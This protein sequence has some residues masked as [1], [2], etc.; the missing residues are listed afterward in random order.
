M[1]ARTERSPGFGPSLAFPVAQWRRERSGAPVEGGARY[2]GGAAPVLHRLPSVPVRVLQL[3][4]AGQVYRVGDPVRKSGLECRLEA[5][6]LRLVG[7]H[8][9]GRRL[10]LAPEVA[11]VERRDGVEQAVCAIRALAATRV[12]RRSSR[13]P[14]SPSTS[15]DRR[16]QRRRATGPRRSRSRFGYSHGHAPAG[17]DL[18]GPAP[19]APPLDRPGC[20]PARAS[21]RSPARPALRPAD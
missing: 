4:N 18:A 17:R 2:S 10:G 7:R 16:D 1:V 12:V 21:R 9:L 14:A 13:Q 11:R 15:A 5:R 20:P 8:S 19:E 6:A 3:F